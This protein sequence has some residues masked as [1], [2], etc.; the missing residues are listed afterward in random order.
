M[1]A[2]GL[3]VLTERLSGM[4]HATEPLH[5]LWGL[6]G[7]VARCSMCTPLLLCSLCTE[8]LYRIPNPTYSSAAARAAESLAQGSLQMT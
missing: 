2:D 6:A 4:I 5:V 8:V 3:Q 1:Y 7:T